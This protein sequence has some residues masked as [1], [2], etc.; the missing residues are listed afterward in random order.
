MIGFEPESISALASNTA[1][2]IAGWQCRA[3]AVTV[4]LL[5]TRL[6]SN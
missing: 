5:S 1:W 2:A 3:S 4:Q 6:R